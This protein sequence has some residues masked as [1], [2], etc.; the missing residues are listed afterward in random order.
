MCV[1]VLVEFMKLFAIGNGITKRI[2]VGY[3]A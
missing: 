2:Y 1:R 3:S